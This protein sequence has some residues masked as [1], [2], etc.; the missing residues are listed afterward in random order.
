MRLNIRLLPIAAVLLLAGAVQMQARTFTSATYPCTIDVAPSSGWMVDTTTATVPKSDK[1]APTSLTVFKVFGTS[2]SAMIVTYIEDSGGLT[3]WTRATKQNFIV[4]FLQPSVQLLDSSDAQVDGYP[5]FQIAFREAD[6]SGYGICD[7]V[8]VDGHVILIIRTSTHSHPELD[9]ALSVL[10]RSFQFTGKRSVVS[11]SGVRRHQS[12]D[13]EGDAAY[14]LGYQLGKILFIALGIGGVVAVVV[15]V[16]RSKARRARESREQE[17]WN[18]DD[19][20]TDV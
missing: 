13:P 16:R 5:A 3:E 19:H 4:G 12:D 2:G 15:L 1:E 6:G 7:A 9:S 10:Y 8:L 18:V 20:T 14:Q 11:S 17:E